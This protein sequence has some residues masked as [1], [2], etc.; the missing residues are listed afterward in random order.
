M[1]IKDVSRSNTFMSYDFYGTSNSIIHWRFRILLFIHCVEMEKELACLCP[2]KLHESIP[3]I[4]LRLQHDWTL[5]MHINKPLPIRF[6]TQKKHINVVRF[7]WTD[8]TLKYVWKEWTW[9]YR[10]WDGLRSFVVERNAR[11]RNESSFRSHPP[12]FPSTTIAFT[13]IF[14]FS[15]F[16]FLFIKLV[17][18]CFHL[19]YA[20][21]HSSNQVGKNR[22]KDII[23]I[24]RIA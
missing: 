23:I 3:S 11:A 19:A 14:F 16:R 20:L 1:S 24:D 22:S 5:Y 6:R 18:D 7:Y 15:F 13:T 17:V 10:Y 9:T 12:L 21:H 4:Y 2:L 8:I